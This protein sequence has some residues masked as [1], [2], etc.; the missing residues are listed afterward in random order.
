MLADPKAQAVDWI[1]QRW[2]ASHGTGLPVEDPGSLP[3]RVPPLDDATAIEVDRIVSR[4][5]HE[6]ARKLVCQ[7]YRANLPPKVMA[8]QRGISV[9]TLYRHWGFV[10]EQLRELFLQTK[11]ADLVR[12]LGSSGL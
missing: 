7:W 1:M 2:A 12:M 4:V 8:S 5:L 9:R 10:L 3:A 6:N 11:H